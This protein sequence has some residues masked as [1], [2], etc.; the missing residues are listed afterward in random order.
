MK[1]FFKR[2]LE[3]CFIGLFKDESFTNMDVNNW[4]GTY[5]YR[6]LELHDEF[7]ETIGLDVGLPLS[8]SRG[9]IDELTLNI[10]WMNLL[11]EELR[12][13]AS[14]VFLLLKTDFNKL[15]EY[16]E[17]SF[18]IGQKK[19]LDQL[20]KKIVESFRSAQKDQSSYMSRFLGSLLQRLN[21]IIED[22]I[23][24]FEVIDV[25]QINSSLTFR[26]DR[27]YYSKKG[28]GG[29]CLEIEGLSIQLNRDKRIF[30][31]FTPKQITDI[32]LEKFKEIMI[33]YS[34]EGYLLQP[35][36]F[37]G[38]FQRKEN[39]EGQLESYR[40][41][42]LGSIHVNFDSRNI[43]LLKNIT[44]LLKFVSLYKT[45]RL[46]FFPFNSADPELLNHFNSLRLNYMLGKALKERRMRTTN[47][48][49]TIISKHLDERWRYETYYEIKVLHLMENECKI[50]NQMIYLLEQTILGYNKEEITIGEAIQEANQYE[51]G[52]Y[53]QDIIRLRENVMIK[54]RNSLYLRTKLNQRLV[55]LKRYQKNSISQMIGQGM[56][57]ILSF[58]KK[59][60]NIEEFIKKISLEKEN[61]QEIDTQQI[62]ITV[63]CPKTVVE[64]L[65]QDFVLL[66][67]NM[68]GLRISMKKDY[69]LHTDNTEASIRSLNITS[70]DGYI[71]LQ[72]VAPEGSNVFK[73]T[74][75]T[76]NRKDTSEVPVNHPSLIEERNV[77]MIENAKLTVGSIFL[78]ITPQLASNFLY[79]LLQ[80]PQQREFDDSLADY[81][82]DE[83]YPPTGTTPNKFFE[84]GQK[85]KKIDIEFGLVSIW[86]L[87]HNESMLLSLSAKP[88]IVI[89]NNDFVFSIKGI[90]LRYG[91][92][93]LKVSDFS[94]QNIEGALEDFSNVIGEFDLNL[95]LVPRS[96]K[97][98]SIKLKISKLLFYLNDMLLESLSS[99]LQEYLEIKLLDPSLIIEAI[100]RDKQLLSSK[101]AA[102]KRLLPKLA[103][104]KLPGA[105]M[106]LRK[107]FSTASKSRISA[108]RKNS[109]ETNYLTV[110]SEIDED[111]DSDEYGDVFNDE[112]ELLCYNELLK[113]AKIIEGANTAFSNTLEVIQ[114]IEGKRVNRAAAA[115]RKERPGEDNKVKISAVFNIEGITLLIYEFKAPGNMNLLQLSD[116]SYSKDEETTKVDRLDI[117]IKPSILSAAQSMKDKIKWT[118]QGRMRTFFSFFYEGGGFSLKKFLKEKLEKLTQTESVEFMKGIHIFV[119]EDLRSTIKPAVYLSLTCRSEF[120]EIPKKHILNLHGKLYVYNGELEYY[121]PLVEDLG[122]TT[123]FLC[124]MTHISLLECKIDLFMLN[125]KPSIFANLLD[126]FCL[127]SSNQTKLSAEKNS[128]LRIENLTGIEIECILVRT[129]V[130]IKLRGYETKEINLVVLPETIARTSINRNND[131]SKSNVLEMGNEI[132]L[133]LQKVHHKDHSEQVRTS[134]MIYSEIPEN[135][136]RM[137]TQKKIK[138]R[139]GR[140]GL[141]S[142]IDLQNFNDHCLAV[143]NSHTIL[144]GMKAEGTT[145]VLKIK[146]NF[147][148]QNSLSYPV[149]FYFYKEDGKTPHLSKPNIDGTYSE[150]EDDYYSETRSVGKHS[151][152]SYNPP[153]SVDHP[154][155]LRHSGLFSFRKERG[156]AA[157]NNTK[158]VF[159]EVIKPKKE[160]RIP[161]F[162]DFPDNYSFEVRPYN[163]D[164][165]NNISSDPK[166]E[167]K[168]MKK[169][170]GD[171][172]ESQKISVENM[173]YYPG[174]LIKLPLHYS[175]SD[176]LVIAA[177]LGYSVVKKA[178]EEERATPFEEQND[179][180][181]ILSADDRRN[182]LEFV[183]SVNYP[184]TINNYLPGD[185]SFK[186]LDWGHIPNIE[187][188]G[189][190]DISILA[191]STIGAQT[192]KG[193][194]NSVEIGRLKGLVSGGS[195][196]QVST[197][198]PHEYPM[199]CI[200][201]E[202]SSSRGVI[203]LNKINR[204]ENEDI[205]LQAESQIW[206]DNK[207]IHFYNME[208]LLYNNY[209]V[210]TSKMFDILRINISAQYWII[211]ETANWIDLVFSEN[212]FNYDPIKVSSTVTA[213]TR[214]SI[215]ELTS[216][217][218]F[219]ENFISPASELEKM[220]SNHDF[221]PFSEASAQL[222]MK[223]RKD[224]STFTGDPKCAGRKL[225]LFMRESS[226]HIPRL[227]LLNE[228]DEPLRIT[229][230]GRSKGGRERDVYISLKVH[231]LSDSF[232]AAQLICICPTYLLVNE[233]EESLRITYELGSNYNIT[234]GSDQMMRLD[235]L[236]NPG[237]NSKRMMYLNRADGGYLWSAGIDV[238]RENLGGFE[239]KCVSLKRLRPKVFRVDVEKTGISQVFRVKSEVSE[240]IKIINT[241]SETF[242]INQKGFEQY[243][244]FLGEND[245]IG[246]FW[247]DPFAVHLLNFELLFNN[248]A[249]GQGFTLD[250]SELQQKK[251]QQFYIDPLEKSG[252]S[253]LDTAVLYS[254]PDY[255]KLG[256]LAVTIENSLSSDQMLVTIDRYTTN[257]QRENNTI[258]R[259]FPR[260]KKTDIDLGII[261]NKEN[262]SEYFELK[263]ILSQFGLSLVD[264]KPREVFFLSLENLI[265]KGMFRVEE[266][267]IPIQISVDLIDLQADYQISRS[268]NEVMIMTRRKFKKKNFMEFWIN[269]QLKPCMKITVNFSYRDGQLKLI[270]IE[271]KTCLLLIKLNGKPLN[272]LIKLFQQFNILKSQ[273]EA[274]L[275]Q[276]V[277]KE[278]SSPKKTQKKL[279]S[280]ISLNI[281]TQKADIF[282]ENLPELIGIFS[283]SYVSR[284]LG[285]L[286]K[287]LGV[288]RIRFSKFNL[289]RAYIDEDI[290]KSLLNHYISQIGTQLFNSISGESFVGQSSK[291]MGNVSDAILSLVS[292]TSS[293]TNKESQRLVK[294]AFLTFFDVYSKA[295]G[296]AHHAAFRKLLEDR[297]I[298]GV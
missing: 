179:N 48:L 261:Q 162:E 98:L 238:E 298:E 163:E 157:Q 39:K 254:L 89:D 113:T 133:L 253:K 183:L 66:K 123:E 68:H 243:G 102:S 250:L 220:F 205:E 78:K 239:L 237:N 35:S 55:E 62:T 218:S 247:D 72:I 244:D 14:G 63:V 284:M 118:S 19:V 275:M 128:L 170:M 112:S 172:L 159:S 187:K 40:T 190:D 86:V 167:F 185:I 12:I 88:N 189:R 36:T 285:I 108:S 198:A 258:F 293:K 97:R 201:D 138:L 106:M 67:A 197:I 136:F 53:A 30:R 169:Q 139:F 222:T 104:T 203:K 20:E 75:S 101:R 50:S 204:S 288:L 49:R 3:N 103:K 200:E 206:Y 93:L 153:Q 1:K 273:A 287:D 129:S 25:P 228:T 221:K 233:T 232:G 56:S 208:T 154:A 34:S 43:A 192:L 119:A 22:V 122:I 91:Q 83:F 281:S 74:E 266:N 267:L 41:F 226:F 80:L 209:F 38:S 94:M 297:N 110:G 46:A 76:K 51:V 137:F 191:F 174:K 146:S 256:I 73:Y 142:I 99:I 245:S 263:I 107:K 4:M 274:L 184:V 23:I 120:R 278:E 45:S 18:Q 224:C 6:S 70:E 79:I 156:E 27:M 16:S 289:D 143:S 9:V 248:Q 196:K 116:I 213:F 65:R 193:W 268:M 148:L 207:I 165:F 202:G 100:Q 223:C 242:K 90:S 294:D 149:I 15:H 52:K 276:S 173:M 259:M 140:T 217:M 260:R 77:K 61:P 150:N 152:L 252:S 24:K 270:K 82:P 124:K 58:A 5:S 151:Q 47:G 7:L 265:F 240:R 286:I 145:T 279:R 69:V 264:E 282:L 219:I 175:D 130:S 230:K 42:E 272:R 168:K 210:Q 29:H 8:F 251:K 131:I 214:S 180:L 216:S 105:F 147:V 2:I 249:N 127:F 71:Y 117:L 84:L 121:E 37:H 292:L 182:F 241:T 95:Q 211:N 177:H 126:T 295:S 96:S 225:T 236:T 132:Q 144:I 277:I 166:K 81:L 33:E 114:E 229:L 194:L 115:R 246:F 17:S 188:G 44:M 141:T 291:I 125:F 155:N 290:G 215:S 59:Q 10:P 135:K 231:Q 28:T 280:L 160:K 21:F 262:E 269:N 195:F 176:N 257:E 134:E 64:I 13:R 57:K 164:A 255:R 296:N 87:N 85:I 109:S 11:N 31:S 178:S 235:F 234:I 158:L 199:L 181:T 161:I 271:L 32:A 60:E 212:Q 283:K 171:M 186:F 54:L 111:E 26:L 92:L 227:D